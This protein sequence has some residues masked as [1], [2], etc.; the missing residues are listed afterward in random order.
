MVVIDEIIGDAT[1]QLS[2]DGL[3]FSFAC[4]NSETDALVDLVISQFVIESMQSAVIR[5][6]DLL[7]GEYIRVNGDNVVTGTLHAGIE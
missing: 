2:G 5:S 4:R 1:F 7:L 3:T 6:L